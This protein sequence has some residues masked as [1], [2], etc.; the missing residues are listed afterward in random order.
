MIL[1]TSIIM[2]VLLVL[3]SS[4]LY[5]APNYFIF[6]G[7]KYFVTTGDQTESF[8]CS[9]AV[10]QHPECRLTEIAQLYQSMYAVMVRSEIILVVYSSR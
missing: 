8:D 9:L 3:S 7:V 2:M 1:T 4:F 5:L 10:L 6:G